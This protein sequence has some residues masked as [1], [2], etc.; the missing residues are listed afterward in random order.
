VE[1]WLG[2]DTL[3]M[4]NKVTLR[5]AQLVRTGTGD[6]LPVGKQ[7]QYVASHPGQLSLTMGRH[8]EL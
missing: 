7:S 2:G 6:S 1:V 3:V 4:M 8:Y 5:Q